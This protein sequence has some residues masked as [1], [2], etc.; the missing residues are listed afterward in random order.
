MKAAK[1][2]K[3]ASQRML[4]EHR[5]ELA[6]FYMHYYRGNLQGKD[7]LFLHVMSKVG[8]SAGGAPEYYRKGA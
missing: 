1:G 8:S 4:G 7:I 2:M 6:R 3:L 5:Y